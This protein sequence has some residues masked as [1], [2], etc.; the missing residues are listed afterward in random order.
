MCVVVL[1]VLAWADADVVLAIAADERRSTA[2]LRELPADVGLPC[3][4]P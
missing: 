1:A 4:A 3:A 2:R